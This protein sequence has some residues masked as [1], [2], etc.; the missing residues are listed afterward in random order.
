MGKETSD[1]DI[2][3]QA[4]EEFGDKSDKNFPT[5][6]FTLPSKGYFYS[7]DNSLSKGSVELKYPT[8]RE[9][10][11][12]TS[13]NLINKGIVIDK[14]LQT[15]IKDNVEYN[16]LLLGDKNGI[17]FAAR[18]LAYGSEYETEVKCPSCGEIHKNY[19]ISLDGLLAKE[20]PFDEFTE[21]QN[22]FDFTLPDSIVDIKFKLLT[23]ADEKKIEVE[24][25]ALKKKMH[26]ESEMSTRLK[27]SII[28]INGDDTRVVINNF[29][30]T[31]RSI[32]SLALR[33]EIQR[34]APDV[35]STFFFTC[36]EC[37]FE[38]MVDIPLGIGFLWPSGRV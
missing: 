17:M 19:S 5:E 4:R 7:S 29:V 9:E 24:L 28:S 22:E 2:A 26:V 13:K 32:D 34:I 12:L 8:A 18:I 33:K 16:T 20:I 30:G 36:E 3:A 15:I 6:V 21:G 37:G 10:D 11:I 38:D 23:H 31:M 1:K 35:E 25:K 14:F 27:H